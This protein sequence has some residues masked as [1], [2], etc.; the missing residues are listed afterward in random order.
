MTLFILLSA[1]LLALTLFGLLYPLIRRRIANATQAEAAPEALSARVLQEQMAQLNDDL[2]QG[3]LTQLA[4]EMAQRE[5][6]A[7]ALVDLSNAASHQ[8]K[9]PT[10]ERSRKITLWALG[11]GLPIASFGLYYVLGSPLM[12]DP[13][14][15]EKARADAQSQMIAGMVDRLASK[16]K[17]NPNDYE[18][19]AKLARSYRVMGRY[20]DAANAYEK[21]TPYV[22]QEP[23]LLID[24][25]EVIAKLEQNDLN[26]RAAPLIAKA[27][28]LDPRHP[29]ALV[30]DG[31]AAFQR[32]DF[33][34]AA[35][36]WTL[37][38]PMLDPAS[39]DGQQVALNIAQ[40][41]ELAKAKKKAK[42][43]A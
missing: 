29:M 4:F 42:P 2:A 35:Q 41:R 24:N 33:D 28:L 31:A 37:L 34:K 1:V 43:K 26:G 6:Q 40:A 13:A 7:R 39:P 16:L 38:L 18:G 3:Q 27:R 21:A 36:I 9:T 11:L 14:S 12:I 5:L 10:P 32:E 15:A 20:Q 8:P 17:D 22:Q 30:L 25:A 19:W 23:D